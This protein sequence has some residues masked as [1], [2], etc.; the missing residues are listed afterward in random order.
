MCQTR[1]RKNSTGQSYASA[2]TSCGRHSVTAP[3]STGSVSTRIAASAAGISCS[4]RM[5]RSKYLDTGRKASLTVTS[6]PRVSSSCW[7]TG[8]AARVANMS[9]GSSRTG[10]RLVVASAAPVIMF[11]EPGP[12]DAVQAY[13]DS[14]SRI[15][16]KATA[17]CTMPCSLR[18]R[19]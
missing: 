3:V 13:A 15:L 5:I 18:A 8:S 16:A 4:G 11:V 17:A 9:L 1:R 2:C 7:R 6:P 10:S 19:W 12:V 14:R